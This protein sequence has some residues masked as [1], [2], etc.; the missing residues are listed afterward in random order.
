LI[1]PRY[2][3]FR[4]GRYTKDANSDIGTGEISIQNTTGHLISL[5]ESRESELLRIRWNN[6]QG[7]F[8]DEPRSTVKEADELVSE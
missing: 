7:G 2:S 8:I 4:S 1:F 3:N 5:L 6:I